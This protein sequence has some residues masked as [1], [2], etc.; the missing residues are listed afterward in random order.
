MNELSLFTGAGGGIWGTK[1]LGWKVN[2]YVE[3][4][5]YCQRV[6]KQRIKDGIFDNAPTFGNIQAFIN[7][8][9]AE[10]YQGLVDVM[11]AGFP[12]TPWSVAG[13]RLGADDK[14]NMWPATIATIREV[15]PQFAFLE[16]V[17]ALS[18]PERIALYRILDEG[19]VYSIEEWEIK[20]RPLV[21]VRI[22]L[23]SYFGRILGDLAESGYDA[24]WCVLG[25]DDVGAP[26][27]R[28]RLWILAHTERWGRSEGSEATG[29]EAGVAPDGLREDGAAE[30][31]D[32]GRKGLEKRESITE[33]AG[34]EQPPAERGRVRWWDIDPANLPDAAGIQSRTG[35]Q[36][37]GDHE[38]RSGDTGQ[39]DS[40][41]WPVESRVGRVV[42]RCPNRV[43]RLKAL[44]NEQVSAVV[45]TAWR[46]LSEGLT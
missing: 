20:I 41:D 25:A 23:P 33:N 35:Q 19:R 3:N 17:P 10:S 27:R 45:A 39:P 13:K 46:L 36:P 12:C 31:A 2:G 16:N 26:H 6:I 11:T 38:T 21:E 9:Y 4:D 34:Q 14:R 43:N 40:D 7:Q 29:R 22:T 42:T 24:R 32:T 44:G 1:L 15:R 37:T 5:D 18:S 28:K 8:G 30:L